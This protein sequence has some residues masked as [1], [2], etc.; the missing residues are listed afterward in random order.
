MFELLNVVL[1]N[2]VNFLHNSMVMN[3]NLEKMNLFGYCIATQ[4]C[5][6]SSLWWH[7]F[8]WFYSSEESIWNFVAW[9]IIRQCG[10]RQHFGV[11]CKIIW[12][13]E[14]LML[15]WNPFMLFCLGFSALYQQ[16]ALS[17]FVD[18]E[19]DNYSWIFSFYVPLAF[20][21]PFLFCEWEPGAV[22]PSSANQLRGLGERGK[23]PNLW[24]L[25]VSRACQGCSFH[26]L[27]SLVPRL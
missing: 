11:G 8:V 4:N 21:L 1:H 13:S 12:K 3:V 22:P 10:T 20:F 9:E 26:P 15:H 14:S 25:R 2:Q 24:A 17:A 7:S 23:V 18:A 27:A 16:V 6:N 5:C 19:F